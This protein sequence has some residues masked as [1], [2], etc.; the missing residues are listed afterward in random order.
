MRDENRRAVE[1]LIEGL[2]RGD[3]SVMDEVF[4]DDAVIEYPQSGERI[5]GAENRRAVYTRF[6][7]L[8]RIAPRRITGDGDLVVVEARFDYGGT[9]LDGV[10]I[11]EMRDGLI[12]RET[13]YWGEPFEAPGWR[14]PWVERM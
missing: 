9:I 13:S 4:H 14:A 1:R 3:V 5:V 11:L 10:F 7:G 12:A 6:P 8:P 2:D